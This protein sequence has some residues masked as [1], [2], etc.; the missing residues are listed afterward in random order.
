M[1]TNLFKKLMMPLAVAVLGI[2]GAFTTMSMAGNEAVLTDMAGYR[3]VSAQ[4]PCEITNKICTTVDGPT[5]KYLV[6]Q[7]LW[8]KFDPDDAECP[9][10]LHERQ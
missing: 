8:G 7:T 4:T 6:T 5:C 9:I 2:A 10:E 1:K 3:F